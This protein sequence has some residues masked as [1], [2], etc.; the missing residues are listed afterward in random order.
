M[1]CHHM[2]KLHGATCTLQFCISKTFCR[3][4]RC[5]NGRRRRRRRRRRKSRRSLFRIVL[6][7][8]A[9]P[10]EVGPPRCRAT[11][12]LTSQLSRRDPHPDLPVPAINLSLLLAPSWTWCLGGETGYTR[13]A[14]SADC[15]Q[16]EEEE[17]EE[18]FIQ[19]H[20]QAQGAIT[21]EME[22]A[23]RECQQL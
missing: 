18:E 8:G 7:W 3:S 17:E 14:G 23:T 20:I 22:P 16:E 4:R 11:P 6:V 2:S 9:I 5:R 12:D 1:C 19:N 10:N 21:N 13:S 15:P